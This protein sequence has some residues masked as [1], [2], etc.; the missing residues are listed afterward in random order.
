MP[1]SLFGLDEEASNAIVTA[2]MA[3]GGLIITFGL[4]YVKPTRGVGPV[5]MISHVVFAVF[6]VLLCLA[7]EKLSDLLFCEAGYGMVAV[8]FPVLESVRAAASAESWSK[9]EGALRDDTRWLTYWI[10][11]GAIWLST[12]W[13]DSFREAFPNFGEFYWQS[14]VIFLMWLQLPF[15]DGATLLY[16]KVT[17]RIAVPLLAPYVGKFNDGSILGYLAKII[18]VSVS[19]GHIS[20]LYFLFIILPSSVERFV[21]VVIGTAYPLAASIVAVTTDAA[22][23]DTQWLIYWSCFGMMYLG[24]LITEDI[25]N[26]VPGFHSLALSAVCYLMLPVFNGAEQIFR[27]VLVPLFGLKATLLK[28]DA[29]VLAQTATRGLSE[30]QRQMVVEA[31]Q[32]EIAKKTA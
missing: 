19:L 17:K 12:E 9:Q 28:R 22:L 16:D 11:A 30:K 18:G 10:A 3:V 26:W 24:M 27:G 32:D 1:L 29:R 25:L 14:A 31:F 6:A 15:T 23:D 4:R 21:V 5:G 20:F 13:L 7:P 2:L 8:V